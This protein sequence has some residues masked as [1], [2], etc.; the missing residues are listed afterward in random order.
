MT[1]YDLVVRG[2]LAVTAAGTTRADIGIQGGRIA[3]IGG[4]MTGTR[5]I[6]AVEHLVLPGAIDPHVHLTDPG[7]DG[8]ELWV[9]DFASGTAAALAGGIT[10][11]GNMTFLRADELPLDALAREGELAGELAASDVILHPV[12]VDP[13]PVVRDQIP[14]L[15]ERGHNSIKFFMSMPAFDQQVL[16]YLEATA[17]A[18]EA[19]MITMIHCEDLAIIE[20]ST[21]RLLA[22]ERRSIRHYPE[23]RPVISEVVATER[24]VAFAAATG[25][26]VYV[27][28]LSSSAALD[29][30]RRA[31]SRG[32]PVYVETRPLYL[33]LTRERFEEA[34]GGKYVGQPPLRDPADVADLWVGLQQGALHVVGSDHAPW[35]LAD[36]TD[37]AHGVDDVRPGVENLETQLAMLY[38]EGVRTGRLSLERLVEV[39]STNAAKLFGLYPRK[40]TIAVGSDADLVI[41]DP[42]L[43]RTVGAPRHSRA[44]YSVYAGWSVTGWPVLTVRR[45]QVVYEDGQVLARP[46]SGEMPERGASRLL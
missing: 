9:D 4:E 22:A 30:C 34:D 27:V 7:D 12:L 19:G 8:G 37:P 46:G 5:E 24:A 33:H 36:K 14:L 16:A 29:V 1:A 6:D 31:Q 28:H 35:K 10:T 18:G 32:L 38:S 21:Q 2:G 43:T 41:L 17:R 39:T 20:W 40:G 11:V 25:A 13:R 26:P 15:R 45:G 42:R 23:S 44:D 3:Q